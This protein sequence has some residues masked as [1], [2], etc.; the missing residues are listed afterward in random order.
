MKDGLAKA[1]LP[2]PRRRRRRLWATPTRAPLAPPPPPGRPASPPPVVVAHP[3]LPRGRGRLPVVHDDARGQ[4]CRFAQDLIRR[5]AKQLARRPGFTGQDREDLQQE[6]ALR[7]WV[8]MPAFD[9]RRGHLHV[10]V[11]TV[12]EREAADLV[13]ERRA[14]KRDPR[15]ARP[16]GTPRDAGDRSQ[17]VQPAPASG[18]RPPRDDHDRAQLAYDIALVLAELP[19][20]LRDLAERLQW[21]TVA[22]AARDTGVPRTTLNDRARR[23]RRV[24][25]R[26]GLQ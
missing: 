7:L 9:A 6:L 17:V 21:Q 10:F 8:R 23:L 3:A 2:E 5:K 16:L 22:Q 12:V 13:R 4:L 14:G 19:P 11:T 24:F 18:R 20:E 15:R 26:A 1:A 25:E